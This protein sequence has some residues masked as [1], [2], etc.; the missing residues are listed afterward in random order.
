[1]T[2]PQGS[3]PG[4]AAGAASAAVSSL[5]RG[6]ALRP[7]QPGD[8]DAVHALET[9]LFPEDAWPRHMFD[10]ELA[11]PTRAYWVLTRNGEIV[12][13]AG[14]M[15]IPPVADVQTIAVAAAHEGRGLGSTLLRVLHEAAVRGGATEMMLEVRADNPRAQALYRRFGYEHIHSR[16]HYYGPGLHALIMRCALVP[17]GPQERSADGRTIHEHR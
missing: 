9:V 17:P 12:A 1:M 8:L 10:E 15:C 4:A 3:A 14:M 2:G 5:P 11:H 16:A 6:Y 7:M 13:Y